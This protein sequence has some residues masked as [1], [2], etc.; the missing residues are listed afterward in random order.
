MAISG[1]FNG[2]IYPK[3]VARVLDRTYYYNWRENLLSPYN[4]AV[5]YNTNFA[6]PFQIEFAKTKGYDAVFFSMQTGNKRNAIIAMAKRQVQY[7]FTVLDGMY[8]TCPLIHNVANPAEKCWQNIAIHYINETE[9][10]LPK[11]TIEEYND[12]YPRPKDLRDTS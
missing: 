6:T 8:N 12:T 2:G 5:Q 3:N 1:L 4:S 9:F 10:L 11:L 7:K